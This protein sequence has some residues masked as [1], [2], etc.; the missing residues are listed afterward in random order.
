M[1]DRF[2]DSAKRQTF[3]FAG[4]EKQR[5]NAQEDNM[6]KL[7]LGVATAAAIVAAVPLTSNSAEATPLGLSANMQ[8]SDEAASPVTNV[9]WWGHHGY[10]HRHHFY[11]HYAFF[12]RFHHRR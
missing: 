6:R 12:P 3:F 4:L 5:S 8:I 9:R 7:V 1:L 2:C 10:S 11:R